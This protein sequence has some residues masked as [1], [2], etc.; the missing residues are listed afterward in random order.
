MRGK[1]SR[2]V[3]TV[4]IKVSPVTKGAMD[5]VGAKMSVR[6]GRSVTNDEVILELIRQVDREALEQA[7]EAGKNLD[8]DK[9]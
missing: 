3:A 7:E 1:V 2:E 5:I 4:T 6:K 8:K 9:K